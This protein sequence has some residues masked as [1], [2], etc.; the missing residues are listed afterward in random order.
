M[1]LYNVFQLKQA[2]I[3]FKGNMGE[4]LG[5]KRSHH[6]RVARCQSKEVGNVL[7]AV[8]IAVG[9]MGSD[10]GTHGECP[11]PKPLGSAGISACLS[12]ARAELSFKSCLPV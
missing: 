3:V 5:C 10:P 7:R 12:Q 2:F 8:L 11:P 9:P 6:A 4:K 1:N